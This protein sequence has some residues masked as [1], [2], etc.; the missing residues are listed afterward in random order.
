MGLEAVSRW[1]LS[2]CCHYERCGA[3]RQ[4]GFMINY[5]QDELLIDMS[6]ETKGRYLTVMVSHL[7]SFLYLHAT[8]ATRESWLRPA[9]TGDICYVSS[10]GQC[11]RAAC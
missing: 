2:R 5:Y 11:H 10:A 9:C 1:S 6:L 7:C 3:G 4:L 8:Q